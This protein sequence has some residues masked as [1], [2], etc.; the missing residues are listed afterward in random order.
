MFN[1][2]KLFRFR[3]VSAVACAAAIFL[4]T[5]AAA[6]AK[7]LR[8]FDINDQL[9]AF[10]LPELN[11]ATPPR[12]F[13]PASTGKPAVILF[14]TASNEFHERKAAEILETFAMLVKKYG[15]RADFSLIYSGDRGMDNIAA[16]LQEKQISLT[17]LHDRDE[18][19]YN[20]LGVYVM[21]VA[22]I[23][24]KTGSIEQV[25]PHTHNMTELIEGNLLVSLGDRS[26]EEQQQN[27]ESENLDKSPEEKTFQRRLNYGRVMMARQMYPQAAREFASAIELM[28]AVEVTYTELG[29]AHIG[30]KDWDLARQNFSAS[31]ERNRASKEAAAGLALTLYHLGDIEAALPGL[32]AAGAAEAPRPEILIALAD[33]REQKGDL[34]QALK[35]YKTALSRLQALHK[36]MMKEQ[37]ADPEAAPLSKE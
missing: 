20:L 28:P 7:P 5:V 1:F 9:P 8:H 13:D 12:T 29:F 37:G 23:T 18:T 34:Q 11:A 10:T 21:P 36:E 3:P 4:C 15:S 27:L 14:F 6:E 26:A 33:I 32:E 17:I 31:L 16:K 19:V 2:V 30:M 24:S 25:V 22:I 35:M